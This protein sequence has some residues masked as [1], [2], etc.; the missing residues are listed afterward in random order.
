MVQKTSCGFESRPSTQ[1]ILKYMKR[2]FAIFSL[3]FLAFVPLNATA[4]N[5]K[6]GI[7]DAEIISE[8]NA[9]STYSAVSD[10]TII[11]DTGFNDDI[12]LF[13]GDV[14]NIMAQ[15]YTIP[16]GTVLTSVLVAPVYTSQIVNSDVPRDAPRNFAIKIFDVRLN[17]FPGQEFYSID[18]MDPPQTGSFYS[19]RT[20]AYSFLEVDLS[21]NGTRTDDLAMLPEHIFVGL[22]NAGDDENYLIFTTSRKNVDISGDVAYSYET[23]LDSGE[24]WY[25]FSELEVSN[26]LLLETQVFPI[27]PRFSYITNLSSDNFELPKEISLSQNYPNP[28]NPSTT[29]TYRLPH[30]DFVEIAVYDLTGQFIETLVNSMQP[31]GD[32]EVRF[33]ADNLPTGMYLYRLRTSTQTL[34]RTMT[35]IR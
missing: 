9:T 14:K 26:G 21:D 7:E 16:T 5:L 25:A 27:R 15:R 2:I 8:K 32:Y 33:N 17:G 6:Y 29:I 12:L 22:T 1:N 10:T 11:Y 23:T 31:A 4:Q 19:E 18:V 30:S 28:F 24:G 34:T 20:M 35:I 3:I 13:W